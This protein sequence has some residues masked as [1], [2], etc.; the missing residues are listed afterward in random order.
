MPYPFTQ[1]PTFAEFREALERDFG[2]EYKHVEG[3]IV[4]E[5]GDSFPVTYFERRVDGGAMTAAVA[6]DSDDVRVQPSVVRTVCRL[7]KIDPSP[8]GLDLG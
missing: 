4:T 3:E 6:F 5:G 2:C 1:A 7:L 8:F